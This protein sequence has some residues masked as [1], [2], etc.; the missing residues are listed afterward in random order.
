M[1]S[2]T[3]I[4]E[5]KLCADCFERFLSEIHGLGAIHLEKVP[6][7]Q[8]PPDYWF[9]IEGE[10]FPVEVTSLVGGVTVKGKQLS[11]IQRDNAFG[12]FADRVEKQAR[13]KEC[14]S[15]FYVI[16]F[17]EHADLKDRREELLNSA[18]AY[19]SDTRDCAAPGERVLRNGRH[20][21]KVTIS[22]Y[23]PYGRDVEGICIRAEW[24]EEADK[25][26]L[27]RIRE[28]VCKK[29]QKLANRGITAS[30]C[31]ILLLYDA[32]LLASIDGIG[33]RFSSETA[34]PFHSV[35]IVR[36]TIQ[37]GSRAT[38]GDLRMLA[39]K[40]PKWME[41]PRLQ[42]SSGTTV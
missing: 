25:E 24:V 35:A 16:T 30:N 20:H 34:G 31:P 5:E 41:R 27:A 9:T 8:D 17:G 15:G 37:P 39:S 36:G 10:R 23:S 11:T 19:I 42:G 21:E 26:A 13:G 40:N 4:D 32:Y 22:K 6:E 38:G 29:S 12:A 3:R 28:S 18:L 2:D 33:R 7:D 1:N 14:L